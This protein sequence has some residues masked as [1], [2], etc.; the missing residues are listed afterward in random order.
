M[1]DL[2]KYSLRGS[3]DCPIDAYYGTGGP[4]H[5]AYAHW[6]PELEI[7]LVE[8]GT[9]VYRQGEQTLTLHENDILIT[10][11][12]TVHGQQAY[13]AEVLTRYIVIS[14]EAITMPA[15][16][17]FQKNFVEPLQ[18]GRLRMPTLLRPGDPAH[19][20]LFPILQQLRN[21]LIYT[22]NYKINRFSTAIAACAALA[23]FC[24]VVD[25]PAAPPQQFP[26][27]VQLCAEHIKCNYAQRL[28]LASLGELVDMH[29]NYLCALFREHA[30]QTVVEYIT[31]VRVEAAARLLRTTDLPINRVAEQCGFRSESLL[32]KYFK[33]AL[34][35]TPNAYRKGTSSCAPFRK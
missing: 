18:E 20:A 27:A 4:R 24:T 2:R 22:D 29:P 6:H 15:T 33:T 8:K 14:P 30:G 10:P 28:T 31:Q 3:A 17:I 11:P 9:T 35:I 26:A 21:C 32:Y 12:N 25:V 1:K 5:N 16:H 13:N 19:T 34:G 7:M 23:P